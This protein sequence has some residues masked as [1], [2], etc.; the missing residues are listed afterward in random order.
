M[1]ACLPRRSPFSPVHATYVS[2]ISDV[3]LFFIRRKLIEEVEGTSVG[4]LGFVITV[5]SV[6]GGSDGRPY[7][8]HSVS[9]SKIWGGA[10]QARRRRAGIARAQASCPFRP[11]NT[12]LLF[13]TQQGVRS[14]LPLTKACLP[15]QQLTCVLEKLARPARPRAD[16]ATVILAE[17]S[18][19][20]LSGNVLGHALSG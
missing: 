18:C 8:L 4:S 12:S 7:I 3:L 1:R 11:T 9:V 2:C 6:S 10:T 15:A 20:L 17:P 14:F 19:L 5:M 16:R 13:T